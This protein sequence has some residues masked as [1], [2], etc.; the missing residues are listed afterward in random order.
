MPPSNESPRC[1]RD[2]LVGLM[3]AFA[4]GG[5]A[6][7]FSGLLNANE[8][9]RILQAIA[10]VDD[11]E[12][13][14][15]GPATRGIAA[16]VDVAR[17]PVDGRLYPNKPPGGTL[18]AIVAYA[19]ARTLH[20]VGGPTPTLRG[21]T[22][23]SRV[24]GA[25]LP[26]V[27]LL[28]LA[29]RHFRRRSAGRAGDLAVVLLAFATPMSSYARVLFGHS[30]AACLLFGG[31]LLLVHATDRSS[32]SPR[33]AFAGGLL[34][35]S[36]ISVE[37]LAAFA[38]I[39]IAVLLL[40]RLR[41]GTEAKIALSA[42]AGALVPVLALAG[43]HAAVFGH[44]LQT[45]YHNVI[46]GGFAQTHAR[47]LLGLSLPTASS[48]FEHLIS[49]WGGLLYWAPLLAVALFHALL[50]WRE[51]DTEARIATATFALYV[52]IVASL[53]QSGGWRVGPRY[54]V[55]AFP[56]ALYGLVGLL[57]AA[58][59]RAWRGALVL[60]LAL[61]SA[62]INAAAANLF[63]HLIPHGNPWADLL[64]PLL[65]EGRMTPSVIPGVAGLVVM[66][67]LPL[68]LVVIVWRSLAP[69]RAAIGLGLLSATVLVVVALSPADHSEAASDLAA[70]RSLWQPGHRETV[71]GPLP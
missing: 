54:L 22:L 34:C 18:P 40:H 14:V 4:L 42:V 35:A 13:A 66:L 21:V 32:A 39:P 15:D 36:A 31:W 61:A 45:G 63:P 2:V 6:P 71:L 7:Y 11:A 43:Y 44:P 33:G 37:Y 38:G 41:A 5:S 27:L 3:I 62:L 58:T 1:G 28:A 68:A 24:L 69:Q 46:D 16:G 9:P 67:A 30:L 59:D 60:G 26:T 70:V 20:A 19:G 10:W 51:L 55:V 50:R 47:G 57:R 49:P 23:A 8:R 25:L 65:L 56:F 64:V 29:A 48:A 52:A 12:L 53:A 17:S